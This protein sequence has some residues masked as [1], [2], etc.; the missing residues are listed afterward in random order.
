MPDHLDVSGL[1]LC[2]SAEPLTVAAFA[3]FGDAIENPRPDVQP[4]QY[5]TAFGDDSEQ[6]QKHPFSP[7]S[8]NQGSAIKYQH[9]S[10]LADRYASHGAPSGKP[11]AA[12]A[13]MFVC[14]AR[15]LVEDPNKEPSSNDRSALFPVTILE[16]HP[17]TTQTFVPLPGVATGAQTRYL[18]IVAPTIGGPGSGGLPDIRGLR[19]FVARGDQAVTYGVGTWHAPMAA[20]GAPGTSVPYAVFQFANGVGP[21]DCQEVVLDG[22]KDG[23]LAVTVRVPEAP[24]SG[25]CPFSSKL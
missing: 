12:V 20:L 3:P 18:V 17:F 21:E 9:V 14:A 19:A 16:R 15:E 8:A 1:H 13:N 4:S 7:V 24:S 6:Q 23:A 22:G 10:R 25:G 2:V 5:K 11:S